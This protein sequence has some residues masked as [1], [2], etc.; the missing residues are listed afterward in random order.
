MVTMTA[1]LATMKMTVVEA[2]I[3]GGPT[4]A[5]KAVAAKAAVATVAATAVA[6][7]AGNKSRFLSHG[8]GPFDNKVDLSKYGF[9]QR[10]RTYTLI[11]KDAQLQDAGEAFHNRYT[12][13]RSVLWC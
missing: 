6:A 5:A 8:G 1:A 7:T 2:A 3:A 13:L 9:L 4:V 10:G 12:T 11:I